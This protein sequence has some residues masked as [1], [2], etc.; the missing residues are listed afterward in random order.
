MQTEAVP[1]AIRSKVVGFEFQDL[2]CQQ[3]QF[4]LLPQPTADNSGV[5]PLPEPF[6]HALNHARV[7]LG[8]SEQEV[9]LPREFSYDPARSIQIVPTAPIETLVV[10]A[11]TTIWHPVDDHQRT[12]KPCILLDTCCL[13]LGVSREGALET[14]H[15]NAL[16]QAFCDISDKLQPC[17][18]RTP[19]IYLGSAECWCLK[20][21]GGEPNEN[22][23][24]QLLQ[25]LPPSKFPTHG[26][27]LFR[28]QGGLLALYPDRLSAFL[29]YADEQIEP[30]SLLLHHIMPSLMLNLVKERYLWTR[31][32]QIK[33]DTRSVKDHLETLMHAS[34]ITRRPSLVR[35]ERRNIETTRALEKYIELISRIE[36]SAHTLSV[37][38]TNIMLLLRH[39]L[40]RDNADS[41][42]AKALLEGIQLHIDQMRSDLYYF[43]TTREQINLH[44]QSLR[45]ASSVQNQQWSRLFT[46]AIGLLSGAEIAQLLGAEGLNLLMV[47]VG[48]GIGL[49][50]LNSLLARLRL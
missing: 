20:F 7:W 24:R 23:V 37:A 27:L 36:E 19:D 11:E 22:I 26:Y 43:Y 42:P 47:F 40:W 48:V 30:M 2:E 45:T 8:Y 4:F 5:L 33:W 10:P 13:Q 3:W 49:W 6:V 50:M 28:T 12:W 41:Q 32:H 9:P 18:E 38:R 16:M 25:Q 21:T 15:I 14:H 31:Y 17:V 44:L 35:I 29:L 39:P 34:W 46:I 1:T